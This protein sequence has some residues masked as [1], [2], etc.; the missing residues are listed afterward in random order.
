VVLE[1]NV[2]KAG[3]PA[4][5]ALGEE[6]DAS[7]Y[8]G[9]Y[10]DELLYADHYV[11][12]VVAR[13]EERA[14]TRG[15]VVLLTADHGESLG[16][17]GWYFQHGHA[18]TPDLAR[19]PMIVTAPG[20]S[21]RRI[22]SIVS[23]VDVAPTLL[24]L[25]GLTPLEEASGQSLAAAILDGEPLLPRAV[26]TDTDGEAAFYVAGKLTRIGGA[27]AS[28][29]PDPEQR[30]TQIQSLEW[31]GAGPWRTI[32]VDESAVQSLMLYLEQSAPLVAA[33]AMRPEYVEQL[34]ALGYLPP[35]PDESDAPGHPAPGSD[36]SD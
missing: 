22:D 14:G 13:L 30:P 11:G 21:P 3:I 1:D 15:S 25:A 27:M 18:T 35:E 28:Q 9:L 33:E 20:A 5:Q 32:E 23:H 31:G 6:R 17:L 7:V 16:E 8:A 12:E 19:V 4:Y 26:F 24:A 10:G 36:D 29:R 2:G 34:R